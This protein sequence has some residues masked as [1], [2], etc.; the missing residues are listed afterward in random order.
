MPSFSSNPDISSF[1][2]TGLDSCPAEEL[3]SALEQS[4]VEIACWDFNNRVI[5]YSKKLAEFYQ[6]LIEPPQ[7]TYQA[8]LALV[9]PDDRLKLCNLI[10]QVKT[11][12]EPNQLE[13]RI[14]IDHQEQWFRSRF[15]PCLKEGRLTHLVEIVSHIPNLTSNSLPKSELVI[16][17][18]A[19]L[20]AAI[21][22]ITSALM[23]RYPLAYIYAAISEFLTGFLEADCIQIYQYDSSKSLWRNVYDY[24]HRPDLPSAIGVEFPDQDNCISNALRRSQPM[25]LNSQDCMGTD[26]EPEFIAQFLGLWMV[27]P[28]QI[29]THLWGAILIIRCDSYQPWTEQAFNQAMIFGDYITL[30]ITDQSQ[31]F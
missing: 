10:E 29:N 31:P 25:Q 5:Y 20:R 13:Y 11:T 17:A 19:Q 26:P 6:D 2:V 8:Y 22:T 23:Y 14:I 18:N 24:R 27:L 15:T 28:I 4:G 7:Q 1:I 21:S 30:A 9:H 3:L 12:L 16:D